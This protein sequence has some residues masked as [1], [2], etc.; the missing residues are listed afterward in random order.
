MKKILSYFSS[1]KNRK[2]A[3][4][5]KAMKP[6]AKWVLECSSLIPKNIFEIGANYAQDAEALR[7]YFKL[8][9]L[10]IWVFEAH[11][12]LFMEI[13]KRYDFHAF[14]AAVYNENSKLSFQA[15]DIHQTK[16]TGISSILPHQF[17]KE[18]MKT[19]TVDSIRMDDFMEKNR[20]DH[21]DFLK[22]DA[23]GCNYEVLEGFG[24]R[25]KDVRAI[26]VEAEHYVVWKGQ[27][28]YADIEALLTANDFSMIYFQRHFSQSDSFWIQ[29]SF[30]KTGRE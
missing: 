20:I 5:G 29:K 27:K 15:V 19:V 14:N 2:E 16:N 23:E 6:F 7:T 21:I 11:P 4:R 3:S 17:S 28:L 25:L 24:S 1:F 13:K 9:P 26:H 18:K 12:D 8:Q 10:D 30:L 22:L